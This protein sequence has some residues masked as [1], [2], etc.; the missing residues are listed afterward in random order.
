MSWCGTQP[1]S[2]NI[3]NGK[4]LKKKER[5]SIEVLI[6]Q[7]QFWSIINFPDLYDTPYEPDKDVFENCDIFEGVPFA[8]CFSLRHLKNLKHF[9]VSKM[10]LR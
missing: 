2:S 1:N 4:I 5:P 10:K 9:S 6:F 3:D 8:P 7:S